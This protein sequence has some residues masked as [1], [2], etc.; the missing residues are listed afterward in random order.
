MSVDLPGAGHA[1]DGDEAARAGSRRRR[2]RRL[3]SRASV[4]ADRALRVD[5]AGARSGIA[6]CRSP[7][8]YLPVSDCGLRDDLVDRARGDHLAAVLP[9]AGPE[10]DDVVGR[11]HRLLVVLDD[12][13]GVAEVAQLLERGEQARVVALVQPDRRLVED[14]EHADEARADLRREPDALRLAAGERLGRAAEREVVE[15]DVDEE[16][17]PLAHFLE[18]RARRSP[19]RARGCPFA[20]HRDRARRSASASVIES[21]TSSPMLRPSI[22]TASDSGLRRRPPHAE[23]GTAS[24]YSSSSM[25]TAS[26]S[27]LLVAALDV[28]E[29][30]FPACASALLLA[31]APPL[32]RR[33]RASRQSRTDV[34]RARPTAC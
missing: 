28:G 11:A 8:R 31:C 10:V 25:R 6:I 30:A 16:A 13:D 1:G 29:D 14:V 26:E 22:V 4:D 18:D 5:A 12:D 3:C 27:R 34:R 9:R 2:S 17:Q 21:S 15:P 20:A 32:P 19:D 33:R 24:M 7:L 23:H